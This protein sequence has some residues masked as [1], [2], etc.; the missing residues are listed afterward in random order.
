[1]NTNKNT[2]LWQKWRV[3]NML[4]CLMDMSIPEDD[5]CAKCCIH[6]D[7]KE[8]CSCRCHG[9]DEWNTEENIANNCIECTEW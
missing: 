3:I 2:I 6:C 4:R 5:K 7:E 9:L 8:T 1:M